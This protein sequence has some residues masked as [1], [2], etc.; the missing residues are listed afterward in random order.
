[1]A[2]MGPEILIPGS[3]DVLELA[4]TADGL[5][6]TGS[7]TR[8]RSDGY[9]AWAAFTPRGEQHDSWTS[10]R[11]DG[12]QLIATSWSAFEVHLELDTGKEI[13]RHFTK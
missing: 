4:P 2:A 9:E 5:G 12:H 6:Y 7:V 11:L 1:M 8:R 3:G 10:V 13:T